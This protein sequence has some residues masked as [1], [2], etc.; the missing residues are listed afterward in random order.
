MSK[1]KEESKLSFTQDVQTDLT[2]G[3][4][5]DFKRESEPQVIVNTEEID[6]WKQKASE[7]QEKY[8]NQKVALN[9]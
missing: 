3:T 9:Q 4:D 5:E 6:E 8:E 2:I 1:L 7:W